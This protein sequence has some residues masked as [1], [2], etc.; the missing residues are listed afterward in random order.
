MELMEQLLLKRYEDVG[1]FGD[2]NGAAFAPTS[3]ATTLFGELKNSVVSGLQAAQSQ[4]SGSGGGA[5]GSTR[6]KATIL[7]ELWRD[8]GRIAETAR[9]MVTLADQEKGYFVRPVKRELEVVNAARTFIERGTP[10]WAKFVEYELP[11]DLLSE[12]QA[13]LDDYDAAYNAQQGGTQTRI[14]A[15][16]SIETLIERGNEIIE[17]LRPMVKNKFMGNTALLAQWASASRYPERDKKPKTP[18][19]I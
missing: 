8:E 16:H 14:G 6:A 13:D 2:N 1:V 9:Q 5:K 11:T 10:L 7:G 12:V 18:P 3:R 19:P 4:Q 15:G 17:E